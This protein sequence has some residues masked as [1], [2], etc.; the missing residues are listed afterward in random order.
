MLLDKTCHSGALALG[1]G[2]SPASKKLQ[3]LR[4]QKPAGCRRSQGF[5]SELEAD[6]PG[7]TDLAMIRPNILNIGILSNLII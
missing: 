5:A 6:A 3:E 1:A 4:T 7:L 2:G